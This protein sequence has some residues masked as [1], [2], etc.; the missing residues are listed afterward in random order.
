M[1]YEFVIKHLSFTNLH[2]KREDILHYIKHKYLP[3]LNKMFV[4]RL[5]HVIAN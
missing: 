1:E 3:A 5:F 4:Y 2:K